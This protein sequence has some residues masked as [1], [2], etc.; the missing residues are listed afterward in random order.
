MSISYRAGNKGPRNKFIIRVFLN[1][2]TNVQKV[3]KYP[4]V[5]YRRGGGGE[6]GEEEV[7]LVK[8]RDASGRLQA[9]VDSVRLKRHFRIL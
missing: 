2:L 9:S 6:G 1:N 5:H 4:G 7:V 3:I 8:T